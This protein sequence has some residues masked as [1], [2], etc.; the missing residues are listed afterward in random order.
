MS[1]QFGEQLV[2]KVVKVGPGKL[3]EY[4][5]QGHVFTDGN[6]R[7]QFAC[8]CYQTT[9]IMVKIAPQQLPVLLRIY[10]QCQPVLYAGSFEGNYFRCPGIT[11]IIWWIRLS[12]RGQVD[13]DQVL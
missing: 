4:F 13:E 9:L 8:Q 2:Y 3:L 12:V 6:V 5:G 1:Q 11:D 10:L 7:L